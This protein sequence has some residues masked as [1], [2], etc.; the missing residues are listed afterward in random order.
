[1]RTQ[2]RRL[3]EVMAPDGVLVAV[4]PYLVLARAS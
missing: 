4:D 1:M 2:T 3:R